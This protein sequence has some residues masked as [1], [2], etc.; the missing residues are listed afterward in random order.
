MNDQCCNDDK[1]EDC[2]ARE[3]CCPASNP[4]LS[5]GQSG[6]KWW[7]TA[8]FSAVMLVVIGLVAY[9]ILTYETDAIVPPPVEV[10]G[11]SAAPVPTDTSPVIQESRQPTT[12]EDLDDA[13]THDYDLVFIV[14][15]GRDDKLNDEV[16]LY[17]ISAAEIIQAQDS[18]SVG[19]F[20]TGTNASSANN[21]SVIVS[22]K[23]GAGYNDSNKY[24]LTSDITETK[25]LQVYVGICNGTSSSCCPPSTP[26]S[27][28]GCCP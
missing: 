10:A 7:K 25:L 12:I 13:F 11:A 3:E 16:S 17:V 8:I 5:N 6:R 18:I 9:S 26:D 14:L 24:I 23:D 21:P 27:S 19:I 1:Q 20:T 15:S 22:G 2:C 28:S 4:G